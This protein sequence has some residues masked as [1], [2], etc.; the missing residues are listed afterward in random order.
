MLLTGSFCM[1]VSVCLSVTKDVTRGDLGNDYNML[2]P[3]LFFLVCFIVT[4]HLVS[5]GPTRTLPLRQPTTVITLVV[6]ELEL[7][8]FDQGLGIV[9]GMFTRVRRSF[10]VVLLLA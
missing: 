1:Y 3:Y 5:A 9:R 4:K 7:L 6:L 8:L 2:Y 10:L